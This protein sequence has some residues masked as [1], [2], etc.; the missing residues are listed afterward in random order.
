[1][2]LGQGARGARR[3]P[4]VVVALQRGEGAVGWVV[5]AWAWAAAGKAWAAREVVAMVG[6]AREAAVA[7]VRVVV[8]IWVVCGMSECGV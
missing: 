1:V 8:V 7:A 5:G 6:V 3:L 2:D 4:V